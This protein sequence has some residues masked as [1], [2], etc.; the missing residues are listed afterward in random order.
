M[1]GYR[2][3]SRSW[4]LLGV[5]WL[6]P[7]IATKARAF[8]TLRI[9]RIPN[10]I[11]RQTQLSSECWP[12]H[13]PRGQTYCRSTTKGQGSESLDD[14]MANVDDL[15]MD[16]PKSS[17]ETQL[18]S[19][20][21]RGWVRIDFG[22][23]NGEMQQVTHSADAFKMANSED[24]IPI[25]SPD[26]PS[27]IEAIFVRDRLVYLKR[28]DLLRLKGSNV[29]GNK[30]RK[31]F[32]LNQIPAKNFPDCIVSYGGPQSNAMVALAAIV[33]SKNVELDDETKE[34][35]PDVEGAT[36]E[37]FLTRSDI[38]DDEIHQHNDSIHDHMA[39]HIQVRQQKR[40]VYYT[41]KLPRFLRAN[42]NGNLFRAK[43]L[44]MELIELSNKEYEAFFGSESGGKAEA[45]IGLHPPIPNKSLWIP[46]GCACA[47]AV[48]GGKI[49]AS[50]IVGFWQAQG[51]G[52]PLSV[53][54]PGGTCATALILHQEIQK[55]LDSPQNSMDIKVVVIPCVGDDVYARRQMMALSLHNG[56]EGLY[57]ELPTVLPP[58]APSSPYFGQASKNCTYFPFGKPDVALL[59]TFREMNN[60]NGVVLD[61]LYGSPAWTVLLRHWRPSSCEDFSITNPFVG[62]E[63]MYVHSGGLEGIT[64][65]LMRYNH[66]GLVTNDEIQPASE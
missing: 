28:D 2:K 1:H 44:G 34:Y 12:L 46:Q 31:M 9:Q 21:D 35:I 38:V 23:L 57:S 17:Q 64:S 45:P 55:L 63:I 27:P 41:K 50:E 4:R 65:Q 56:G 58:A 42:Q 16:L 5:L 66:V 53:F 33:H 59:E 13:V 8:H 47:V 20:T 51:R 25:F 32:A 6:L 22:D 52:Q 49:L 14:L 26:K 40:F 19:V 62:R 43:L 54:L 39:S 36:I 37:N 61:L 10:K 7:M 30:A 15:L 29:S 18:T 48:P 3:P 60:K 11:R 24:L